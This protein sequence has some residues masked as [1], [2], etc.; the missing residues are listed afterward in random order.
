MREIGRFQCLSWE[1]LC[2]LN[3]KAKK[4][5][6]EAEHKIVESNLRLVVSM[7]KGYINKGLELSDLIQ[8]GNAGLLTAAEKFESSKGFKFSTYATFWI[9]KSI[10][11]L[12]MKQTGM[13]RIPNRTS[14]AFN[15]LKNAEADLRHKFKREPTDKELA[16]E[17]GLELAE[18]KDILN[19]QKG[20]ESLDRPL[21]SGEEN[22]VLADYIEYEDAVGPEEEILNL[23]LKEY[24]ATVLNDLS[25]RE[26]WVIKMHY[27]FNDGRN[28][29]LRE[30]A[31]E[32]NV[33]LAAVCWAKNKALDKLRQRKDVRSWLSH[34]VES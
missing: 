21:I 24:F 29:S 33:T 8:A 23:L 11:D 6:K 9:K 31:Q 22:R 12:I 3:L 26:R 16:K 14:S 5:D 19:I 4:G 2:D 32:L 34:P 18:V 13:I 27:G 28:F 10:Q 20:V 17:V 25:D 7:A 1:E 30:I 15:I